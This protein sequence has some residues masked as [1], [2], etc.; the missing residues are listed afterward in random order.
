MKRKKAQKVNQ[1]T[2]ALNTQPEV[3]P[4]VLSHLVPNEW[5]Q[6]E[7]IAG[8]AEDLMNIHGCNFNQQFK[9]IFRQT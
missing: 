2:R 3:T 4:E 9:A 8:I 7:D 6:Q 1:D 5:Y